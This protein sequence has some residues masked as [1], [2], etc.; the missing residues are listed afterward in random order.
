MTRNPPVVLGSYHARIAARMVVM[1]KAIEAVTAARVFSNVVQ[2]STAL[3]D[4]SGLRAEV[5][6]VRMYMMP[7]IFEWSGKKLASTPSG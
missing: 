5:E 2:L 3:S 6:F 1:T 7:S 4:L